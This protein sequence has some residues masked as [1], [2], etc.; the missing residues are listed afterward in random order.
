MAV[1]NPFYW[2]YGS[3]LTAQEPNGVD[4]ELDWL[5]ANL[6]GTQGTNADIVMLNTL[7]NDGTSTTIEASDVLVTNLKYDEKTIDLLSKFIHAEKQ[8]DPLYTGLGLK[9]PKNN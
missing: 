1:K 8:V 4:K 7:R 6:G 3:R 9:P 2:Y 5:I